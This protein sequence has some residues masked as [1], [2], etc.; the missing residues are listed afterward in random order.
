MKIP[1]D[2]LPLFR[3]VYYAFIAGSVY[4]ASALFIFHIS[5]D[6]FSAFAIIFIA[7]MHGFLH[8]PKKQN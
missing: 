7:F 4:T 2:L 8:K 5:L 6:L 1:S 3:G